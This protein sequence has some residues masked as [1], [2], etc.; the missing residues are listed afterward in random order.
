MSCAVEFSAPYSD[1][2]QLEIRNTQG[3]TWT[4][5]AVH[6]I[7]GT[8]VHIGSYTLPAGTK[9]ISAGQYGFVEY[10]LTY[11]C[12]SLPYTSVVFGVPT[13][14]IFG[15]GLGSLANAFEYGN[16]VGNAGFE[17]HRTLLGGV[18]VSVGFQT[19]GLAGLA[20]IFPCRY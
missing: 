10:Y 11:T 13:T 16:C 1:W 19:R 7:T 14:S 4:G 12:P 2:Y 8:T 6:A 18:E 15:G 9:G 3:M 17:S 5:T 20:L